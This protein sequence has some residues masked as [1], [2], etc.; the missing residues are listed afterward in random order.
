M[1]TKYHH[2]YV[3]ETEDSSRSMF[4]FID[5]T[6]FY[7]ILKGFRGTATFVRSCLNFPWRD[8]RAVAARSREFGTG[9]VD[10]QPKARQLTAVLFR[11]HW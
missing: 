3:S 8:G 2:M 6:L 7:F 9:S 4:N 5:I 10:G 1:E 11:T